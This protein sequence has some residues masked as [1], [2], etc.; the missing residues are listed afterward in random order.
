MQRTV[1][2]IAVREVKGLCSTCLHVNDCAYFKRTLDKI[3]NQCELFE[4]DSNDRSV[5]NTPK[6]LCRNC[7]LASHCRLGGRKVGTW[8][9]NEFQ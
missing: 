1:I 3:V 9:C 5:E 4:V 6:G 7:D 2:D 8:H